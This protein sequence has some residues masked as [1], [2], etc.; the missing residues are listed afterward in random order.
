MTTVELRT[1]AP[2]VGGE[3]VA[4]DDGG[5]VVFVG[6]ALP[7]EAVVVELDEERDRFARGHVVDVL[8]PSPDRV[9]PPCPHL[10]EGCG[11]CDW[12]HVA[13]PR[14]RALRREVVAE[15]LARAGGI[16]EPTVG[17]G[18]ELPAERLRTTLR[19]VADHEGRFALR[20][21]RS[22][23]PVPIASCLVAHPLV[24]EVIAALRAPAGT[25]LTVR[26]GAR[27]GERMVVASP[28]AAGVIAPEGVVVVGDEELRAGHRA[29]I[30][31]EAAGRRWRISAGSFFQASPEG[32]EALVASVGGLLA[33]HAPD[34][35]RLVDLCCGVGLFAGALGDGRSVLGVERSA[36]SVADARTN[37]ADRDA[38]IVKV[39]MDRWRPAP[40]D[41][42]VADPARAG[43]GRRVV[44]AVAATGA[45]LVVLVSC[46]PGA[47]GRDARLLVDAGYE[48]VGSEVIDLF[49]HASHVEV[50]SGFRTARRMGSD[51]P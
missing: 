10:A 49:G 38:R 7:G 2:A 24:D 12:Q 28:T 51:R 23:E 33:A 39:A 16:V 11:G 14:Q 44:G 37:L 17:S 6:G 46:D 32:A 18:P 34:D 22:H 47:L 42:V 40:A 21:R 36:S 8:E 9:A 19:G 3:S 13:V 35:G 31:E 45:E 43:L 27:S 5:R 41:V 25:T 30:H 48:H 20:R 15:V 50:V 26:V 1:T 4:R 29:W